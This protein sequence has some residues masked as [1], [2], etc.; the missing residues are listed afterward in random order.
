ML[1]QLRTNRRNIVILGLFVIVIAVFIFSFGP[2]QSGLGEGCGAAA[3]SSVLEVD[4]KPVSEA[5]WRFAMNTNQQGSRGQR[6]AA[7]FEALIQR[8][9]KAQAAAD[10]GFVI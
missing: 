3:R 9:L 5:S 7:A 2:Q 10:A 4:G 6:A 8:E 1:E